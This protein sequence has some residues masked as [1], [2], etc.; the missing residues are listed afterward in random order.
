MSDELVK[1]NEGIYNKQKQGWV[2]KNENS[3]RGMGSLRKR[4]PKWQWGGSGQRAPRG[5]R[6]EPR[7]VPGH[8]CGGHSFKE[9]EDSGDWN[10]LGSDWG[11]ALSHPGENR[12]GG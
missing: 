5:T 4:S 1:L 11:T 7:K 3:H 10:G 2:L 6:E 9:G 8:L 12:S